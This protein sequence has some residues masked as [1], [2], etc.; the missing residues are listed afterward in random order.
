M[1]LSTFALDTIAVTNLI[2]VEPN[3]CRCCATAIED[4]DLTVD[5]LQCGVIYHA[6]AEEDCF[7]TCGCDVSV[8]E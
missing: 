5:C 8:S 1:S 6:G 4:D 3:Y 2:P 7:M